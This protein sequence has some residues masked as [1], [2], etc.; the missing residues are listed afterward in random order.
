MVMCLCCVSHG[1]VECSN[2]GHVGNNINSA[3]VYFVERF[4]LFLGFKN[5]LESYTWDLEKRP[6][7]RGL[8]YCVP[9]LEGLL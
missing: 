1:T 4:G 5:I 7:Y 8:L 9:I 3:V 2:R 6:L